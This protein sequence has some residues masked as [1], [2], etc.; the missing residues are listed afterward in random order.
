MKITKFV[1]VSM[2]GAC[3]LMSADIKFNDSPSN[4]ERSTNWSDSTI[5]SYNIP[6]QKAK[7]SV[8]NIS[9]KSTKIFRSAIDLIDDPFFREFFGFNFKA[10]K[11]STQQSVSL[12]S[13]VIVSS[14]GYIVTNYHVVDDADEI[15]V[16]VPGSSKEY[17]AKMVGTDQKTDLAVIKIEAQNLPAISFADSSKLLEGDVVFAI[18]NPLGT[19]TSTSHGIISAL[20]ANSLG[21]NRY[22]DFIQTDININSSNSGGALI[23]STGALIGINSAIASRITNNSIGFAIPSN[24]VKTIAKKLISDGK[25]TRGYIGIGMANLTEEQKEIYKNK[26]GALVTNVQDGKAA[27]LAGLK[28]GDL[29]I[30]VD[31]REIKNVADLKNLINSTEPNTK[32]QITFERNS[33]IK[34]VPVNLDSLDK[35]NDSEGYFT[36]GLT[37]QNLTDVIKYKNRLSQDIRGILITN[38]K[39]NSKAKSVGFEVGDI[40]VQ[41][42]D[43]IISDINEYIKEVKFV[44]S[45]NKKMMV[46]INR[47]G[48]LMGLVLK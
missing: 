17:K 44:K 32:I 9:T 34:T 5:L 21:L 41:V 14:N 38:V 15:T 45:Q 43:K 30:K 4:Y 20:N 1:A 11:N 10:I 28:R 40:I 39:E 29:I 12:G 7:K 46:W 13:G 6:I 37:I 3:A 2:V 23:N 48:V 22:E 33:Q 26:Q 31:D 47:N 24:L 36:D 42:N 35:Q 25:V 16:L 8:V 18:G 19:A 27:S